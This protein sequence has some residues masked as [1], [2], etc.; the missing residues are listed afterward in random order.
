MK[1]SSFGFILFFRRY[2]QNNCCGPDLLA[3]AETPAALAN[4]L[5]FDNHNLTVLKAFLNLNASWSDQNGQTSY[6]LDRIVQA[7]G[8]IV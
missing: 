5:N 3:Q 2:R 1:N 4:D 6:P 8:V 7:L